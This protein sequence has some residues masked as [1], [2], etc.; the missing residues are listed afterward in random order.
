MI[1]VNPY[2]FLQERSVLEKEAEILRTA[3]SD[4]YN[5]G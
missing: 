2:P 4:S 1:E 3:V 5:N